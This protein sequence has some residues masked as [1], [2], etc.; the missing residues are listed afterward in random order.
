M[1]LEIERDGGSRRHLGFF[2]AT[3]Q[4]SPRKACS[5]FT[6]PAQGPRHPRPRTCPPAQ[7]D[8][9]DPLQLRMRAASLPRPVVVGS[10]S[11]NVCA[12]PERLSLRRKNRTG[13]RG[14]RG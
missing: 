4:R 1:S 2:F 12:P 14:G 10:T 13:F 11:R 6:P 5:F 9:R 8:S 3:I 7:A